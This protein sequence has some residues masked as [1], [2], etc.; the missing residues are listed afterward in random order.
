MFTSFKKNNLPFKRLEANFGLTNSD[1]VFQRRLKIADPI[2][3]YTNTFRND[4]FLRARLPQ[5]VR[6]AG[7]L[8]NPEIKNHLS[9][10]RFNQG[11]VAAKGTTLVTPSAVKTAEPSFTLTG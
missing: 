8:K 7:Q 3:L 9:L 1:N 10:L 6:K 2:R 5:L 11:K 4:A